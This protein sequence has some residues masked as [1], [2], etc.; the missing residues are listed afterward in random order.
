MGAQVNKKKILK[1]N[2]HHSFIRLDST[3][4]LLAI[5]ATFTAFASAGK[6]PQVGL[7]QNTN[8]KMNNLANNAQSKIE[9]KL[10]AQNIDLKL[11]EK[12]KNMKNAAGPQLDNIEKQ[13]TQQHDQFLQN[14]GNKKVN[15]IIQELANAGNNF[16]DAN[17][18]QGDLAG[19]F[20]QIGKDLFNAGVKAGQE[21][22]VANKMNKRVKVLEK[23]VV[24]QV[25][26]LINGKVVNKAINDA[27]KTVNGF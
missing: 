24:N 20:F 23:N 26:G 16:M 5:F 17:K 3:M 9:Q 6:L 27:G 10:A 25:N 1:S 13:A 7:N 15:G 18:P 19:A 22:V 4:K 8:Q 2:N 14:H 11:N 12:F 21:Q